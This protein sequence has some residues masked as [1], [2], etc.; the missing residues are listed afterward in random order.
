M[1]LINKVRKKRFPKASSA[2]ETSLFQRSFTELDYTT[3][4]NI[5]NSSGQY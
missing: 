1:C 5:F 2:L 3:I 4:M